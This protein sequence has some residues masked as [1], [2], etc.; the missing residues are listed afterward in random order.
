[1]SGDSEATYDAPLASEGMVV[2]GRSESTTCSD[3][4]GVVYRC[5]DHKRCS[6]V[7]SDVQRPIVCIARRKPSYSFVERGLVPGLKTLRTA[8]RSIDYRA[9]VMTRVGTYPASK[10]V[11]AALRSFR[12]LAQCACACCISSGDLP[13]VQSQ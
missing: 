4:L 5:I 12:E 3:Q 8:E 9:V 10:N 2:T 1:M 13:E 7:R 6:Y 11:V